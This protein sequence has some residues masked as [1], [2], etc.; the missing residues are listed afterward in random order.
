[1]PNWIGSVTEEEV[2]DIDDDESMDTSEMEKNYKIQITP[3]SSPVL[4]AISEW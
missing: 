4:S 2:L 3:A 1:M